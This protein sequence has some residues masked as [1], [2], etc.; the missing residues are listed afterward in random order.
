MPRS[1]HKTVGDHVSPGAATLVGVFI[2][3]VITGVFGLGFAIVGS[4]AAIVFVIFVSTRGNPQ[5]DPQ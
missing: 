3:N 1:V 4:V 2:C 5:K